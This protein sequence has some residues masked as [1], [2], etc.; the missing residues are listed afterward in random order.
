MWEYAEAFLTEHPFLVVVI[1]FVLYQKWMASRPFPTIEGSK[2][3]AVSG[4]NEWKK[5]IERGKSEGKT[6]L[7]DFYATWCP[8]CRAAAPV[9]ADMSIKNPDV[10]FLKVNAD[11]VPA[12]AQQNAIRAYPTFKCFSNG[13]E[14]DSVE[15]WNPSRVAAM[16]ESGK[17]M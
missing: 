4:M 16:I 13:V 2:V 15:G 5:Q 11:E 6:V 10:I 17:D 8:P 7:V 14:I 1:L 12:V 9:Y 3:I